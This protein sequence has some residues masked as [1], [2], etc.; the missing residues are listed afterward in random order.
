MAKKWPGREMTANNDSM[1]TSEKKLFAPFVEFQGLAILDGGLATALEDAGQD[2]NNPLWS[3]QVLVNDPQAIKA[4]HSAYL[5]A[6]AD[7]I[8]TSTYQASL[9]GFTG[10]GLSEPMAKEL[11]RQAVVLATEAR[12]EFWND[13][14]NRQNRLRPLVAASIGP[15]GAF[16][17][18]G[19]E[20]TGRYSI[21]DTE[22]YDF[23]K[24]RWQILLASSADL[25]ACET[26]PSGREALVL[27]QLISESPQCRAWFSFSCRDGA[28]LWDGT[29]VREIAQACETADQV[30]ALGINCTA[31]EHVAALISEIRRASAKP[32]IVYPN[33]GEK[34]DAKTKTW[35]AGP[36]A[37]AWL[38][39]ACQWAEM[40]V[41]AIGGC[42]RVGPQMISRLRGEVLKK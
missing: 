15:Y 17:A 37:D 39:L 34:Y 41:A 3:A 8:T 38:E 13:P 42:C 35:G 2:L 33:L 19:S 27:L 14:D 7:C 29:P 40:G 23:H 25:M 28:H 10:R 16:L 1:E 31:P 4:V 22:I 9:P 21:A 24:K 36:S 30:E 12:E 6:G 18:D 32:I 5:M 26:L 20:Y 11:M